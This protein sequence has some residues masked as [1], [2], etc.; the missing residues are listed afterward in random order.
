[1][2]KEYKIISA[3]S[4]QNFFLSYYL[5]FRYYLFKKLNNKI[6]KQSILLNEYKSFIEKNLKIKQDWF[7]HNINNLDFI[8][9][10]YD[11]YKKNI[12]ALELGSYEGNSS[13][14]FLKYFKNIR[15]TCVDTFK[16]SIEQGNQNFNIVFDNFNFNIKD[17]KDSVD[18]IES[19]SNN[20]FENIN[21]S[22][23]DLIYID[24]SHYSKDVLDDA[25]NSF[26]VLNKNGFMIFD[27]FLW[28]FYPNKNDNPI[29]GIKIF[30]KKNFF[31]LKIISVGYQIIIKKL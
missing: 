6:I 3:S 15:L 9:K 4:S 1:M 8:F 13:V 23:Y 11:L 24:G 29:G 16:G 21:K 26:K 10:K 5:L 20:F 28:D 25:I 18:V 27:D 17:F 2:R 19:D 22:N 12:N 7:T 14:F 30:L 31:K